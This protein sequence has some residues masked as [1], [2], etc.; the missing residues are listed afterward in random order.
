[1]WDSSRRDLDRDT[2]RV[3]QRL[4]SW[5]LPADVQWKEGDAHDVE[6]VDFH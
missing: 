1:V 6:I 2:E 5:R 3:F 4:G